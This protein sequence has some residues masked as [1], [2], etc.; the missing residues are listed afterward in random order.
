MGKE[1][2]DREIRKA[3]DLVRSFQ[4]EKLLERIRM[5][6]NLGRPIVFLRTNELEAVKYIIDYQDLVQNDY[7]Q[8]VGSEVI[9]SSILFSLPDLAIAKEGDGI[10]PGAIKSPTLFILFADETES[11]QSSNN[12]VARLNGLLFKFVQLYKNVSCRRTKER[13]SAPSAILQSV[14]LVVTSATPKIPDNIALYTEYVQQEPMQEDTLRQYLSVALKGIDDS[15][16]LQKQGNRKYLQD[17]GYLDNLAKQFKGLPGP[18]IN[19]MLLKI[20]NTFDRKVYWPDYKTDK[21]F[22]NG[23]LPLIRKEK[24]QLIATSSIL[25]LERE[26]D[27]KAT[28]LDSLEAYLQDKARLVEDMDKYRKDWI[29][30]PVKG[31]LFAGIPGGGKSMMAKYT[32]SLLHIPLIKMDMGDVQN[33]YVG[34]SER[35]MVEALELVNAM[36]PCVL[37]IDEIEKSFA[38]SNG[39]GDNGVTQRLFGKFLTWMQEKERMDVC[40]FVFATANDVSKLP[41]ELFRNG[42]FDAKFYTFMPNAEECGEIFEASIEG[43]AKDYEEYHKN[44][45]VKRRLFD[46]GRINKGLFVNLLDS[47]LCLPDPV[48]ADDRTKV[49]RENKFFTGAD[50]ANV[51]KRAQEMYVLG[52]YSSPNKGLVYGTDEFIECLKKAVAEIRTYGETDLEKIAAC[53]AKMAYNNFSPASKG[54]RLEGGSYLDLM[55]FKGYDEYRKVSGEYVMYQLDDEPAHVEKMIHKYDRC[56]FS[57]VRNVLNR[58]R[59]MILWDKEKKR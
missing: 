3:F 42:R 13:E 8:K 40:C 20:W 12:E 10:D 47:D 25:R 35:R 41:P 32:A 14:I 9:K 16:P 51:I 50:I 44:D 34:E 23:V 2:K 18:K 54:V 15:I 4:Y 48:S 33:K 24:E 43:L 38:G 26:S 6:H 56:L 22:R 11:A 39:D 36:S 31:V 21:E 7:T 5:A 57:L 28:G 58:D 46:S 29:I 1:N 45:L 49:T 55:P 53:Y 37:W 59:E 19:Q 27:K 52:G 17:E 30:S